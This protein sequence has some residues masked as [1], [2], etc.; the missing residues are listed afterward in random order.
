MIKIEY[1][2]DIPMIPTQWFR[3]YPPTGWNYQFDKVIF[4]FL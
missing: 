2:F 4:F 3:R 1:L